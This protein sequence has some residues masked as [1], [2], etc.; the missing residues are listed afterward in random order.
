MCYP[1]LLWDSILLKPGCQAVPWPPSAQPQPGRLGQSQ[2]ETPAC[3]QLTLLPAPRT[4][5]GAGQQE[6]R[7]LTPAPQAT[8]QEWGQR[9]GCSGCRCACPRLARVRCLE[10]FVSRQETAI[11]CS[12]REK[13]AVV[14]GARQMPAFFSPFCIWSSQATEAGRSPQDGPPSRAASLG[15]KVSLISPKRCAPNTACPGTAGPMDPARAPGKA[16]TLRVGG[17]TGRSDGPLH[18]GKSCPCLRH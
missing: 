17:N 14:A 11:S 9:V 2:A 5:C 13:P 12:R 6:A 16:V 3:T 4:F 8:S 10:G 15:S 7:G 18:V 1:H